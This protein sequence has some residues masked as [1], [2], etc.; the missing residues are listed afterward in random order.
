MRVAQIICILTISSFS[1]GQKVEFVETEN[2]S[3]FKT[4]K[5]SIDFNHKYSDGRYKCYESDTIDLPT[6]IFYIK[7][8]KVDGSYLKLRPNGYEIGTYY[9]DSLWTFLTS[10]EDTTFKIGNWQSHIYSY[11]N[12]VSNTYKMPYD[13]ND[14]FIEIWHFE[15]GQVAREA[16]YKKGFGLEKETLW[17]WQTNRIIKQRVVTGTPENLYSITYK[18][19]SISNVSISQNGYIVNLNFDYPLCFTEPPCFNIQIYSDSF[20]EDKAI[21]TLTYNGSH[22]LTDFRNVKRQVSV[23]ENSDGQIVISY[24]KKNGKIKYKKVKIK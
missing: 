7:N 22:N 6:H 10:P 8:G 17:E 21:T 1:F 3:Y 20:L 13:L 9:Q 14:K 18:N 16:I 12:I 2:E 24:R 4:F 15:T 23:S 11:G 5:D 19:D